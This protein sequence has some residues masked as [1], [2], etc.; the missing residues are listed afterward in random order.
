MKRRN[1]FSLIELLVVIAVIGILIALAI[2]AIQ[3]SRQAARRTQCQNNL[4]QIGLAL[5]NY[6]EQ[7]QTLPPLAI[8]GGPPGEPLGG[9][10]LPIGLI[11]RVAMGNSPGSEPDRLFANWL[12]LMLPQYE[13]STLYN[14]YNFNA[15][16]A[17]PDN[18]EIRTAE[19]SLL[20][21]PSDPQNAAENRHQRDYL[22]G[23]ANNLYAR[24]NYAMNFGPDRG[25]ARGIQ[26]G[27]D[28]GFF[29]DDPDVMNKN[30]SLWGSGVGGFNKAFQ[31]KDFTAGQSNVVMVEE[32]RA[33][34]HPV[35][36]RGTWALGFIGASGTARHGI[37]D[38]REDAYG[39]NN[40]N[41]GSDD[42]VGCS[43]L[44]NTLFSDSEL[45]AQGMPC[46]VNSPIESNS[47]AT[48]RSMHA[49]G[50]FVLLGDSSVH[51]INNSVAIEI[52]Y[53][54][55]TRDGSLATT[56]P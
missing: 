14:Q 41:S 35:D 11:D 31:L 45:M 47:Q 3:A 39:P 19:I 43:A 48:A 53:S 7:F 49:G 29:L 26:P 38:Q 1:G 21:C 22:A 13:Q 15:P 12:L 30:S 10:A 28:D 32:V 56:A 27:C 36:P 8:W 16:V 40:N 34:I 20:K 50:V 5:H 2:P 51:F 44:K 18:T 33:G 24:G 37:V 17:H 6:H 4:R 23:T 55:H 42:V 54:M 9:G 46:H 25:C 52:W